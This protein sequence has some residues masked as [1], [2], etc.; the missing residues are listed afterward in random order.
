MKAIYAAIFFA[1][2][3]ASCSVTKEGGVKLQ[4]EVIKTSAQCGMCE[5]TIES[6]LATMD[7]ISLADLDVTTQKLK[8]KFD[9]AKTSLADIR[10]KVASVG[11]QAD[12][13]AADPKAYEN[14]PACCQ[15]GGHKN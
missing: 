14:L 10:Q 8:V 9:P 6:A 1:L 2:L 7:G 3:F 15:L 5:D 12:E 4:S 13:V 11:Y